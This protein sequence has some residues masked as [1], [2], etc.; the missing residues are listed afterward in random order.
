MSIRPKACFSRVED[1][2][3]QDQSQRA[4]RRHLAPRT[5][6]IQRLHHVGAQD[7]AVKRPEGMAVCMGCGMYIA[8]D[9][10]RRPLGEFTFRSQDQNQEGPW[11]CGSLEDQGLKD[12]FYIQMNPKGL[13]MLIPYP[14][15]K[16]GI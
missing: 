13:L 10:P 7:L 5:E 1:Q 16:T 9:L 8:L 12:P 11:F 4:E 6:E 14:L 15:P 2:G 3:Y